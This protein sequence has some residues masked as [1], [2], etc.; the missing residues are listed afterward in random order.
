MYVDIF[1]QYE[2]KFDVVESF[3]LFIRVGINKKCWYLRDLFEELNSVRKMRNRGEKSFS[4]E[5][6][7]LSTT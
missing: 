5:C 1:V 4:A 2:K 7:N 3:F 6:Y